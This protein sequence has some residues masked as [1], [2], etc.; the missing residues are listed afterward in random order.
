M[1]NAGYN[2]PDIAGM[3][4]ERQLEELS[5]ATHKLVDKQYSTL[6]RSLMPLMEQEG[7]HLILQH[8]DLNKEQKK[9]VDEYFMKNVY[10]VLTPMAVDSSRPF[11][12]IRN[13][14]LNIGA[15]VAKKAKEEGVPLFVQMSSQIVYGDM[16]GLG[17]EKLITAETIPSEPT[18][19]GKS[20]MMLSFHFLE[21]KI[22]S[23]FFYF[24]FRMTTSHIF[25]EFDKFI[26]LILYFYFL[27]EKY[28]N[29][30]FIYL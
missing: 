25:Y 5:D 12:L 11:P 15:L 8:E 29:I 28:N 17:E 16:S 13:K 6:T 2:K 26:S 4:P 18:I 10:P 23:V 20:K 19:Y 14:T 30:F 22:Y 3:T 27:D 24:F 1:A 21:K 9:Y 7:I